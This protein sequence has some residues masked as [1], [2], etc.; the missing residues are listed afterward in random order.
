MAA[1]FFKRHLDY[2]KYMILLP[3]EPK[4]VDKKENWVRFEI[5]SLY[6]GYGLTI[7]NALRRVLLSSLEGA[8]VTQVK[9]KGVQ[10]E[11]STINGVSEDVIII[12]MNLK[13]MRFKMHADELQK[14][15]LRVKGEKEVKGSDFK[16]PTQVELVNKDCHIATLTDKK[17]ELEMEIQ[18]EKGVGYQSVESRKKQGKMEIGMIPLDSIFTPAK[19]VNYK[20]ENMRVGERTDFDR[21][22]LEVETDG[23]IDAKEA[24]TKSCEILVN[25]F[26]LLN[27]TFQKNEIEQKQKEA[28][29]EDKE[30]QVSKI[31]IEDLK[32]S[33]RTLNALL[34]KNIKN[35]GG[36]LRKN[37]KSLLEFEGM[38]EKGLKEIK[39][40]L[41]KLKVDIKQ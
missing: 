14:A 6:P 41:K 1:R 29:K 9:I 34:D 26:S 4:I 40:A 36:L 28:E 16:F 5:E 32:I 3:K 39:K 20:I 24:F 22:Y 13:Q 38:G 31:K 8:A 37:E 12:M 33:T 7:G 19:R 18:I 2:K 30:D 10:H 17:A 21:L 27:K 25:H 11:F 15:V 23:T 35:V